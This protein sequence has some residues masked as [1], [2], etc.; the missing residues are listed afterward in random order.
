MDRSQIQQRQRL[1]GVRFDFIPKNKKMRISRILFMAANW[2]ESAS[3]GSKRF[4]HINFLNVIAVKQPVEASLHNDKQTSFRPLLQNF[5]QL[6][7]IHKE[8]C[9]H[10]PRTSNPG[11]WKILGSLQ[12]LPPVE[13][14]ISRPLLSTWRYFSFDHFSIPW[15]LGLDL[16]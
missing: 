11:P 3:P 6:Y 14:Q 16:T 15:P 10:I 9:H 8:D 7:Q 4:E 2:Q 5:W 12:E 1:G 13:Y